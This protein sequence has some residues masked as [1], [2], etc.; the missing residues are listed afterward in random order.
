MK[1][2]EDTINTHRA[3]VWF[4]GY[5]QQGCGSMKSWAGRGR[6]RLEVDGELMDTVK[7]NYGQGLTVN[8][9]EVLALEDAM[10]ELEGLINDPSGHDLI[11]TSRSKV[12]VYCATG[13]WNAHEEW[14]VSAVKRIKPMIDKFGRVEVYDL[15]PSQ[16]DASFSS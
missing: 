12:A 4:E 8:Q 3:K 2:K 9:L 14:L 16:M 15:P 1:P 13:R 10:L 5:H 6:Y 11:I 7:T